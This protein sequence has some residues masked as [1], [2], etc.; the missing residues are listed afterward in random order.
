MKRIATVLHR[1]L[2]IAPDDGAVRRMAEQAHFVIDPT[3][4]DLF[5]RSDVDA[6][7]RAV[8]EA[9]L[10]HLPVPELTVEWEADST[11]YFVSLRERG[12]GFYAMVARLRSRNGR[13]IL[14]VA[15]PL[16][17][18]IVD[19]VTTAFSPPCPVDGYAAALAVEMALIATVTRGIDKEVI[20]PTR[21]NRQ[22]EANGKPRIPRHTL[23][24]IGTVYDHSD[25]PVR[26]TGQ[27]VPC[28]MHLRIGHVRNQA[29]GER[30]GERKVVFIPPV[31]VN[32]RPGASLSALRP[33]RVLAR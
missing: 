21:L 33:R 1:L 19:G 23:V 26:N 31:I 5:G 6:C 24:R 22:R 15:D 8:K 12:G 9:D 13:E 11:R 14:T 17:V 2:E 18:R 27:R 32:Y 16:W 7:I 3:L 10:A 30:W 28:E 20:E 4:C 29:H 25:R